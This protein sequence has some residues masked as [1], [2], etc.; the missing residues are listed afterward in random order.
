M[1]AYQGYGYNKIAQVLSKRK[2]ISPSAYQAR[3]S[4]ISYDKNPFDWNLA[5]IY[6]MM[7]NGVYLGHLISGKR[8][9]ASFKSKR[10]VKQPEEKW[11]VVEN[12]HEPIISQELWDE[13][14]K[15]LESRKRTSKSGFV[16]IFA[17]LLKCDKCGYALGIA[18]ASNRDNYYCCNT[19]KK[20]GKDVCSIHYTRYNDLYD[21]ILMELNLL[22]ADIRKDSDRFRNLVLEKLNNADGQGMTGIQRE[23]EALEN[24]IKELDARF[25]KLYEDKLDGLL[26]DRK[27]KEY[28]SKCE[29]EQDLLNE[30][31]LELRERMSSQRNADNNVERFIE[32]ISEYETI[33]VLDKELLNRLIDKIVVSDKIKTDDG[34]TQNIKIKYKFI[35]NLSNC[36]A[37]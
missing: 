28:S 26:S 3:R 35:G 9:K 29:S 10:E 32:T 4:G 27:F 11:I 5:T 14:H 30:Q 24:R 23:I 15:K 8:R 12:T 18:N 37:K 17:G 13:A 31:L 21:Y 22:S 19:Y 36:F 7:E 1:A 25:D 2:V 16:N 34:Y 20:K 33:T 6:R